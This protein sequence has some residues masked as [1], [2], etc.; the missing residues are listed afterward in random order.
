MGVMESGA[1]RPRRDAERLGDLGGRVPEVVVQYED[2]PL[3]GRQPAEPA[4]KLV[5]VGDG[6]QVI[7]RGRSVDRQ[8]A[9]VRC[10]AALSRRLCDADIDEEALEPRIEA[11]RIAESPEV[12]PGD[13]QRVL[14]GILGP[15]DVTEDALGD[16]KE[17]VTPNADQVDVRLPIPVPCRLD[18]IAI[19]ASCLA[20]APGGGAVRI[21]WSNRRAERSFFDLA[22]ATMPAS[23]RLRSARW[24]D[25]R[26]YQW[27][28][29]THLV[30]LVLFLIAHGASAFI[31]FRIRSL[32]D[33][34]LVS[35]Y[36]DLSQ[37]ASRSMYVGLLVLLVGGA[38]AATTSDLWTKPWVW[39]SVIVLI[40]VIVAMYAMAAGYYYKLR[41]LIAGKGGE[42]PIGQEALVAYLDSRR[43]EAL[44]A[45]GLGG[46]IVLVWMMVIKPG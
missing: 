2:R 15:I 4:V 34:A 20:V 3:F 43:P 10:P 41:D 45:V 33:A 1:G 28:V 9:K 27:F 30:G 29:F 17:P 38:G 19:H 14:Q 35:D 22:W 13:H 36:L 25:R 44:T 8:H 7:G 21:Y 16:R 5:P 31:S 32:R 40:A 42:P 11:V 39:G 46:L 26:M 18:E 24:E 12:T 6:E 37:M 23:A